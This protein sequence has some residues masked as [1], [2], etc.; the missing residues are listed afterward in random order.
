MLVFSGVKA[1]L[2]A[3]KSRQRMAFRPGTSANHKAMIRKYI[4]FCTTHKL[5]YISPSSDTICMYIEHLAQT[6]QAWKSVKNYVA[7]ISLLHK[8]VGATLHNL[9]SFPVKLMMRSLPLTMRHIP[10]PKAAMTIPVLV[11][12]SD[13]CDRLG[14]RG[15]VIKMA[16]LLGFFAFL[17][18]SNMCPKST[19]DRSRHLTR[20]DVTVCSPGLQVQI[21]WSKTHQAAGHANIVPLPRLEHT[22]VDP[23]TTF[24]AMVTAIPA[25][26]KAPLLTLPGGQPLL[27]RQVRGALSSMLKSLGHDHTKLSMHSLRRGGA[28]AAY[29]AGCNTLDI[30]RHGLWASDC[31]Q[32]YVSS[33]A[34]Q[35]SAICSALAGAASNNSTQDA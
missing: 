10:Q 30:Q 32:Q 27:A 13:M 11:Q 22:V 8:Y 23:V 1:L 21:K 15:L 4:T 29:A 3:A 19:F 6:F 5:D 24:L 2:R 33:S 14:N 35:H 34:P 31:F 9:D 17:R 12:L 26:P 25:P 7:A 16:L 28:T 20:G 18:C